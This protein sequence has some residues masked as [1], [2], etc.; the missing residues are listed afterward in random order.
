MKKLLL[1]AFFGFFSVMI[2]CACGAGTATV[3]QERFHRTGLGVQEKAVIVL[4]R[5]VD[6]NRRKDSAEKEQEL[7]DCMRQTMRSDGPVLDTLSARD[8][9]T[10]LDPGM[11]FENA[12]RSAEALLELLQKE[13]MQSRISEMGVRY[14]IAVDIQTSG[15]RSLFRATVLDAKNRVKSGTV[16]SDFAGR[17]GSGLPILS[18]AER[19]A[20]AGLGK[21]VYKFIISPDE[22]APAKTQ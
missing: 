21:A 13:D 2:L 17:I 12:P 1:P 19:E 16:S 6:D 9:R 20:C 8:F 10:T 11:A 3:K 7:T 4:E 14:F 5:Y 18:G 15:R 22:P